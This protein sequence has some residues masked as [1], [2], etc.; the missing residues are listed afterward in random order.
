MDDRL[1]KLIQYLDGDLPETEAAE[2]AARLQHDKALQAGHVALQRV[3][4]LLAAAPMIAPP[5][6]FMARFEARLERR[7]ARRR[8]FIGAAVISL[9]VVLAAALLAWSLADAGLF[10][11]S[12]VNG[13]TLQMYA[14]EWLRQIFAGLGVMVRVLTLVGGTALQLVKH[15]VF[16]GYVLLVVGLVSLWAQVLRRL[17]V[18]R[19]STA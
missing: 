16:W 11:L 12:L 13:V 1:E 14:V 9:V 7:L 5:P 2:L 4:R 10:L 17:G 19:T 3:E 8:N 6:D 18:S 15:P